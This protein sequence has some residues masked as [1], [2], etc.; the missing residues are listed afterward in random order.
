LTYFNPESGFDFS[1]AAGL[2]VNLE[3]DDT[4]YET[5]NELHIDLMLNRIVSETRSGNLSISASWLH[6]LDATRRLESDYVVVTL[7]WVLCK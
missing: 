3:N 4:D 7:S 6:D 2:L 5:G 1:M